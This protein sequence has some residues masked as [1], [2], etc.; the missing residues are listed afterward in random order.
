MNFI[1]RLLV[2]I[3]WKSKSYYLIYVIVKQFTNK[4]VYKLVKFTMNALR[5]VKVIFNIVI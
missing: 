1:I 5:L 3:N 4:V 2:L